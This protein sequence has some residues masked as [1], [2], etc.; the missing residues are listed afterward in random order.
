MMKPHDGDAWIKRVLDVPTKPRTRRPPLSEKDRKWSHVGK[1]SLAAVIKHRELRKLTP[2]QLEER[3]RLIEEKR[4]KLQMSRDYSFLFTEEENAERAKRTKCYFRWDN[5]SRKL[6]SSLAQKGSQDLKHYGD[7]CDK[8]QDFKAN[9][10]K[11]SQQ[12]V[13]HVNKSRF[14]NHNGHRGKVQNLKRNSNYK[15]YTPK[16][17]PEPVHH[18]NQTHNHYGIHPVKQNHNN[19]GDNK[20][21]QYWDRN[22]KVDTQRV[23]K[24]HGYH[25][26]HRMSHGTS[27]DHRRDLGYTAGMANVAGID[28]KGTRNCWES[29]NAQRKRKREVKVL[30][31][32]V[33]Y[34]IF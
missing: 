21:V 24:E 5:T 26:I 32:D 25:R 13:H 11:G 28:R 12:S 29:E 8:V 30:C 6:G 27:F 14:H 22:Y 3:K 1:F 2:Q 17:S 31:I 10:Q 7:R 16:D 9:T 20:K 19:Y 33:I 4:K 23:A 15:P 18:V 34:N